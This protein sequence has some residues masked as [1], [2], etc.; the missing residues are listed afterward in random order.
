M[1]LLGDLDWLKKRYANEKIMGKPGFTVSRWHDAV[2]EK[3][4]NI[5]QNTNLR[6][7]VFWGHAPN[8]QSRGPDS[9]NFV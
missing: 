9:Y 2:L 8:S 6:A 3:P 1:G 5:D 7:V 4:E